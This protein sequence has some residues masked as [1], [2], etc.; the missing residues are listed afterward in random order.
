MLLIYYEH[1][2]LKLMMIYQLANLH[3]LDVRI[4]K[5]LLFKNQLNQLKNMDF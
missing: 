4:L 5:Q 3:F 2:I 1:K